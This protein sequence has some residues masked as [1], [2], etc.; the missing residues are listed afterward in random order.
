[1][2]AEEKQSIKVQC[3]LGDCDLWEWILQKKQVCIQTIEVSSFVRI[4]YDWYQPQ[5]YDTTILIQGLVWF[6]GNAFFHI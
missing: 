6:S 2:T 5:Q 1:M 4:L 3:F